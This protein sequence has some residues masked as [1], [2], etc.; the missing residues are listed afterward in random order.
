MLS[1]RYRTDRL[2]RHFSDNEGDC[3]LCDENA[4]GGRENLLLFSESLKDIRTRMMMSLCENTDIS[5]KI[6]NFILLSLNSTQ[7]AVQFLL[8]C[9]VL[10]NVIS[11]RQSDGPTVLSLLFKFTR[12]WCYN[13][14][15]N[16]LKLQGWW[17]K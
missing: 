5:E 11:L 16:K 15:K 4:P 10:P 14:H 1:G 2:L 12:S 9:S 6:K 8:D 17:H 7:T 13:I 3:N